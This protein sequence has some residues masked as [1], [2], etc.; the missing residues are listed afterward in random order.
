MFSKSASDKKFYSPWRQRC[1]SKLL[2]K[3]TLNSFSIYNKQ[4]WYTKG[5]LTLKSGRGNISNR[6]GVPESCRCAPGSLF[7]S[8]DF[9][10]YYIHKFIY[11]IIINK[12]VNVSITLFIS[13]H[14][15]LEIV[16]RC[17]PKGKKFIAYLLH[18]DLRF[19]K[20]LHDWS[21]K[22]SEKN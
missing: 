10:Y 9:W 22:V 6:L 14:Y 4:N 12:V 8:F 15:H 3:W 5:T 16:H 19:V 17:V 20:N 11:Y 21:F 1:I 13:L 2:T 7:I 18:P